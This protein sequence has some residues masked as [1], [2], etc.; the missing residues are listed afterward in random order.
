MVLAGANYFELNANFYLNNEM[1]Y[2][3]A[4]PHGFSGD[5]ALVIVLGPVDGL[6]Y[7]SVR[8][9]GA[10]ARGVVSLSSNAKLSGT[11]TYDDVYVVS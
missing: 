3:S 6:L 5:S 2:W 4:S 7:D 11:G 1:A 8:S 10:G 9:A